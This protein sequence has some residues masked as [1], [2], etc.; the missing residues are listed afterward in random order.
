[1]NVSQGLKV[2]SKLKNRGGGSW[3]G[4]RCRVDANQELK[5]LKN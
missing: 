5:L 1:M 3:G 4:G 2:I